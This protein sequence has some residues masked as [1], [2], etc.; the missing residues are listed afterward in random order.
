VSL[1][2]AAAGLVAVVLCGCGASKPREVRSTLASPR[3]CVV[4]VF[5]A[6]RMVTGRV[7]TRDEIGAVR[8]RIAS[9][10]KVKTFAFVS[11]KLALERMA[12]RYPHMT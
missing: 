12:K 10:S 2:A 7:A 6:S 11:T 1:R 9:S 8:Q 3:G 4:H 5:C